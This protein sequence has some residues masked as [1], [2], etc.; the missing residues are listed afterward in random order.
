M[1]ALDCV[2]YIMNRFALIKDGVVQ[3]IIETSK[4]ANEFP[5][6]ANALVSCSVDVLCN[7]SYDGVNF[8]APVAVIPDVTPRQ[9]RQALILSG[10]ALSNIDSAIAN[11]PEPT[12]SLALVEWEYSIAFERHRPLVSQVAAILGWNDSQLDALWKLAAT[13]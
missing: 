7:Y 6:I 3:S 1:A 5:D 2:G 4:E 9:M 11:L 10:V 8:S 12:K 13:L